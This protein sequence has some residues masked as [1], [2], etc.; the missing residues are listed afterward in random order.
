MTTPRDLIKGSLSLIGAIGAGENIDG[1]EAG[2]LFARLNRM[3]SGWSTQGALIFADTQISKV[4]TANVGSYTIG[5][6][7]AINTP[8]PISIKTAFYR[9]G[10][11]DTP[12]EVVDEYKYNLVSTKA[13]QGGPDWLYYKTDHP[14]GTIKLWPVPPAA[15]TLFMDV[16]APLIAFTN[17]AQII[18]LPEGYEEAIEYNYAKR[19]SGIYGKT[20]TMEQDEI[21]RDTLGNIKRA[22]RK[23][24]QFLSTVN[25]PGAGRGDS[26]DVYSR[27]YV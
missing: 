23:N 14:L 5:T 10:D 15:Y 12:I 16:E 24:D 26:F 9:S 11:V 3:I 27:R 17:L 19:I 8:R 22:N 6:G 18:S 21:A 1:E 7:G 13:S 20:L 25:A 2:D 4:L